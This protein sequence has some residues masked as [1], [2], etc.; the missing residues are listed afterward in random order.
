[1]RS[2]SLFSEEKKKQEGRKDEIEKF[3]VKDILSD[4]SE[5]KSKIMENVGEE[6]EEGSEGKEN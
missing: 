1:M 6:E 4:I 3:I 2:P 5:L